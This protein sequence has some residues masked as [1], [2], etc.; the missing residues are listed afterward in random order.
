MVFQVQ[1]PLTPSPD[2][3]RQPQLIAAIIEPPAH[4]R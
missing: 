1:R 4:R 3:L 2:I